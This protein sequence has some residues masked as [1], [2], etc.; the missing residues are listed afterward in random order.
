MTF[1][2]SA[3][4]STFI[5]YRHEVDHAAE[6]IVRLE[7]AIDD[8]VETSSEKMRAVV[9]ALQALRG[10]AKL[11]AVTVAVEVGDFSRFTRPSQLMGYSGM[12]P[13]EYS[14][15]G[16]GK[17]RRGTITKA[18]NSHL[19]RVIGEAA[20]SYRFLPALSAP[21]K[22]RQTGLSEDIKAIGWTAQHRLYKRYHRLQAKG[23][24]Q[25][26]VVTAV[27]RELLGFLWDVGV[28]AEKEI[29]NR[30][31]HQQQKAA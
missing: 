19:R 2:H 14:T 10:I 27:G 15:G 5:D 23:L 31:A 1:E 16:P 7:Q 8:A 28:H 24:P 11:T 12:V 20:W 3:H 9:H 22:K 6:R 25:Q 13:S 18:G 29:Q 4:T 30:T 21:L 26:K 17:A